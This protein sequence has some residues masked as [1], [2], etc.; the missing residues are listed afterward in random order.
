MKVFLSYK[1][2]EVEIAERVQEALEARGHDVWR[3]K[4]RIKGGDIWMKM[5]NDALLDSQ[6]VVVLFTNMS[7]QSRHVYME[8]MYGLKNKSVVGLRTHKPCTL[9]P[10]YTQAPLM[11]IADW[12]R[13]GED[14][15]IEGLSRCLS[16]PDKDFASLR[17]GLQSLHDLDNSNSI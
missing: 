15:Q 4:T 11:D 8:F 9:A 12:L 6:R 5:I 7:F 1:S 14:E 13:T 16:L 2:E 10:P 17:A 3:D